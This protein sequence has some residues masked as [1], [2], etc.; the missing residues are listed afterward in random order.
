MADINAKVKS[1]TTDKAK[2]FL[3]DI[4]TAMKMTVVVKV[5]YN[6][7]LKEMKS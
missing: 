3:D 6:D 4:F 7:S 1:S 5:E 2:I